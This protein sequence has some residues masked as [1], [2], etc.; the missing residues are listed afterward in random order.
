MV[1]TNNDNDQHHLQIN[2]EDFAESARVA[3]DDDRADKALAH[4]LT[5][6]IEGWKCSERQRKQKLTSVN[7][8]CVIATLCQDKFQVIGT[9]QRR[10]AARQR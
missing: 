6:K 3:Y 7:S 1:H 9:V 8:F 5:N 10:T 2:L 4:W